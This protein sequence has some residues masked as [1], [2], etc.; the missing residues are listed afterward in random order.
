MNFVVFHRGCGN[1]WT[2]VTNM[3]GLFYSRRQSMG[4]YWTSFLV[5]QAILGDHCF[6]AAVGKHGGCCGGI[7]GNRWWMHAGVWIAEWALLTI[8]LQWVTPL[9]TRIRSIIP[10]GNIPLWSPCFTKGYTE[11]VFSVTSSIYLPMK[12]KECRPTC[13]TNTW[14]QEIFYWEEQ[15]TL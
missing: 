15:G 6:C 9:N 4:V 2:W 3:G 12:L 7:Q 8:I 13:V 5:R 14:C 1:A 10:K 11:M